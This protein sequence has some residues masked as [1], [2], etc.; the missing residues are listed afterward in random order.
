VVFQ[1]LIKEL[2]SNEVRNVKIFTCS[3]R[4][5]WSKS[6]C[7]LN[8][9]LD[10]FTIFICSVAMWSGCWLVTV[11]VT[12]ESWQGSRKVATVLNEFSGVW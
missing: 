2:E 11:L 10:S 9:S 4:L 5:S 6:T 8:T 7:R 3:Y 1:E 12:L